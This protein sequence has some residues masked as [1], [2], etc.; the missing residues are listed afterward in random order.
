M[1]P[2]TV[3]MVFSAIKNL[4]MLGWKYLVEVSF[5]EIYNEAINDLLN[6]NS[7]LQYDIRY[8]EGKG[9]IVTNLVIETV[10]SAHEMEQLMVAAQRNRAVAV[11]NFNEH[12]SRSHAITKITLRGHHKGR[13]ILCS[14]SINL[15]D[16][17]GSESAKTSERI[18]ETK[19]IN[20]SLSALGTVILALNNKDSHIPYRNSKLTYLLQSSLGGD[21]KTLMF[22]N[23]S[24]LEDCFNESLNS[25]KFAARVKEVKT[26]SKQNKVKAPQQSSSLA[27]LVKW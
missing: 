26:N 16:L 27:S 18:E 22:V 24:P 3:H 9:I 2:R 17:A 7:G 4:E 21:S 6:P 20:K 25:L 23:I 19:C 1:I 10:T 11:T 8:N 5:M 12:S 14:G 15:V 13:S